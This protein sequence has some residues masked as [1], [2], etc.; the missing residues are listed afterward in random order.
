MPDESVSDFLRRMDENGRLD[1]IG[2][3]EDFGYREGTVFAILSKYAGR[4]VSPDEM[5]KLQQEA[6]RAYIT[7][8]GRMALRQILSES[9]PKTLKLLTIASMPTEPLYML[10]RRL[11]ETAWET[12]YT[13]K[14]LEPT[15]EDTN[16]A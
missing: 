6:M 8:Q 3:G 9:A 7:G 12:G 13:Y 14:A 5:N 16:G 4:K 1:G 10:I 15:E 2:D 11:I